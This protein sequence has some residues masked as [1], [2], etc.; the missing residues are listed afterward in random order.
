MSR[1]EAVLLSLQYEVL[2]QRD[3]GREVS[4]SGFTW[5]SFNNK[6]YELPFCSS[7]AE[8]KHLAVFE[9]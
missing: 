3:K 5:V 4:W 6:L 7:D 1:V 2:F 8:I 9:L